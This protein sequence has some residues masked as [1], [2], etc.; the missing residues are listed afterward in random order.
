MA[1]GSCKKV[2]SRMS[3]MYVFT[4]R[5]QKK[6]IVMENA[7]SAANG[8]NVSLAFYYILTPKDITL[9]LEQLT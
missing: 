4:S 8:G 5:K 6:I 9:S 3:Y 7:N 1:F 2:C